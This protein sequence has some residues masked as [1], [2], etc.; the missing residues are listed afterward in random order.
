MAVSFRSEGAAEMAFASDT[1]E[2]TRNS[3][4]GSKEDE[5]DDVLFAIFVR[6]AGTAMGFAALVAHGTRD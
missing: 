5:W 6:S 1:D 3:R 2:G 4:A